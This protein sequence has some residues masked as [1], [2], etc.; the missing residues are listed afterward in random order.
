MNC[1]GRG[2]EIGFKEKKDRSVRRKKKEKEGIQVERKWI[3][4]GQR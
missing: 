2:V 1:E 3:Y 4:F